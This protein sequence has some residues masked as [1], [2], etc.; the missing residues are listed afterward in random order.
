MRTKHHHNMFKPATDGVPSYFLGMLNDEERNTKYE[1]AIRVT[2]ED[3]VRSQGRAPCVMDL[4]GGTG[5]LAAL[6]LKHGAQ[7]V[8]MIEANKDLSQ[9][10]GW[11]LA[12]HPASKYTIVRRMSTKYKGVVCDM[13][14]SELLGT[15]SNSESMHVYVQDIVRRGYL[16]EFDSGALYCV[17]K[18]VTMTVRPY[19]C[20]RANAIVTGIPDVSCDAFYSSV[21]DRDY[22]SG[23]ADWIHDEATGVCLAADD[24]VPLAAPV[25]VLTENY[26]SRSSVHDETGKSVEF[27]LDVVHAHESSVIVAEWTAELATGVVLSHTLEAVHRL[28][29]SNLIA[30]WKMWGH[31]YCRLSQ[32][33][34]GRHKFRATPTLSNLT[35]EQIL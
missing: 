34:E 22:Q 3:F 33:A 6:C 31:V 21:F 4:G 23:T 28:P 32:F 10:A 8:V 11:E 29:P 25:T 7:H 14:V 12:E 19:M 1:E 15:M 27:E 18:C 9:I 5:M 24:A 17:P 26:S 2:I 35:L 16:R 13:L 30:R 20:P